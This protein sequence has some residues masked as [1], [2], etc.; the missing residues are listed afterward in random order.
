MGIK[1]VVKGKE[2]IKKE[3]PYLIMGNHQSLFDVFV[4][5]CAIPFPFVGIEASYHFK[6]PLWGY[7]IKKW[8]NIPIERKN[9][10]RA[11]ESLNIAKNTIDSGLS[12]GVLPEGHRTTSGKIQ[13]FKKGPFYL[14]KQA[15][16]DILPFGIKG[17]FDFNKKGAF[18]INPGTVQVKIGTPINYE[19]FKNL[20]IDDLKDQVREVIIDLSE[21]KK[22]HDID[23]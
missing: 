1:L 18:I 11:I 22:G 5:P 19:N 12:M 21:E 7:M 23:E 16:I 15:N 14:A 17:L 2:N 20:N 6:F 10:S 13:P 8:G 9:R 4:I 3:K